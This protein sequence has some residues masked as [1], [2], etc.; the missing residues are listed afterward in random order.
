MCQLQQCCVCQQV[1]HLA[2]WSRR[3]ACGGGAASY[4]CGGRAPRLRSH[5]CSTE[6]A[7]GLHSDRVIAAAGAAGAAA[8]QADQARLCWS[9]AIQDSSHGWLINTLLARAA[10]ACFSTLIPADLRS[11]PL[12][13]SQRRQQRSA[14]CASSPAGRRATRKDRMQGRERAISV[15]GR[16]V[17]APHYR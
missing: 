17:A 5:V 9:K 10:Y 4:C 2:G 7:A 15:L 13:P 8:G 3:A 1:V 14:A 12:W 6:W 11:A 16:L